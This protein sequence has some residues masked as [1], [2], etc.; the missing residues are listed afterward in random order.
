MSRAAVKEKPGGEQ[1]GN[2][3]HPLAAALAAGR[4]AVTPEP[5]TQVVEGAGTLA[6]L[7]VAELTRIEELAGAMCST[8]YARKSELL[9]CVRLAKAARGVRLMLAARQKARASRRAKAESM[10]RGAREAMKP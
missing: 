5:K 10:V 9:A 2:G 8:Y 6:A 7:G 1:N 4:K 3:R